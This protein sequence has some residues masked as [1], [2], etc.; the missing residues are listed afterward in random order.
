VYRIFEFPLL[1]INVVSKRSKPISSSSTV[2]ALKLWHVEVLGVSTGLLGGNKNIS[3]F[4]DLT[5]EKSRGMSVVLHE[6]EPSD[7]AASARNN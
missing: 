1:V 3:T 4:A 7:N 5:V 6:Q 2:T